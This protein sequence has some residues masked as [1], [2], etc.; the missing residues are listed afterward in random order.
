[1]ENKH[2]AFETDLAGLDANAWLDE[3]DE[4]CDGLGFFEQ[5]GESHFAGFLEAG[6]TLLVTFETIDQARLHNA[7][8]EPRGFA[9]ARQEGWSLLAL[10]SMGESWFRDPAIFDLF[11]RLVDDGFFEDFDHI[12]FYGANGGGYAAA[13]YSVSAPGATVIALRPQATLDARLTSWD[14][15]YR[16]QRRNCFQGRYGYAPEMI[17]GAGAVFVVYDPIQRLDAAHAALF[18]KPHVAALACPL[19]G[20]NIDRAFDRMGIHDAMLKLAMNGRLDGQRFKRLL[21]ARR[22]DQT[23]L[24][25]LVTWLTMSEHFR[26]AIIVCDYMLQ[27]G[28]SLFFAEKRESLLT[29]VGH[30]R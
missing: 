30:Q 12:V 5:L 14:P 20:T 3:I 21:R 13:A 1:M 11:D 2:L 19:L 17:D 24:R 29:R 4:V 15:R 6:N 25:S 28:Q 7:D 8:A 9:Y 27:R 26:L 10:L 22:Y 18:H 23:Y 16:S